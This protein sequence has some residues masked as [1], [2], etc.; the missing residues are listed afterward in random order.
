LILSMLLFASILNAQTPTNYSGKWTFDKSQSKPGE[1]GSF[2]MSEGILDITQDA[3]SVTLISTTKQKGSDDIIHTD[4]YTL[5][6]KESIEKGDPFTT[7]KMAKWSDDK[8]ILTITTI[9]TYNSVDY[10]T[11]DTYS[12]TDNGKTLTVT[13]ASKN[14]TGERKIISVYLKK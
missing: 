5:D 3:N 7:K 1:G 4:K 9:M 2:L 14:P 8:K 10:R 13:S 12:L 6:G 11:D